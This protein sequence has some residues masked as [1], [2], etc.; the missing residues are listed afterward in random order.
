MSRKHII[1]KMPKMPTDKTCH[2]SEPVTIKTSMQK[3]SNKM[4][5]VV[6][7]LILANPTDNKFSIYIP[8]YISQ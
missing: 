7:M 1:V 4:L 8:L 5:T 3:T 2:I 6:F